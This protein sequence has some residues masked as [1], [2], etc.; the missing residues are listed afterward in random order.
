[1]TLFVAWIAA[2]D[3]NDAASAHNLTAFTDAL[4]AGAD[5]HGGTFLT[6]NNRLIESE[7]V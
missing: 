1:L 2:H 5:L 6:E 7:S 3:V 4:D